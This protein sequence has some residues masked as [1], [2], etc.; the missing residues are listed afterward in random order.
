M[1]E[2]E[3]VLRCKVTC[4]AVL[5]RDMRVRPGVSDVIRAWDKKAAKLYIYATSYALHQK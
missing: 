2:K 5:S 1:L 3:A 4:E